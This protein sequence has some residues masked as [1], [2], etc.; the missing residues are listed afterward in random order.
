[1]TKVIPAEPRAEES[2]VDDQRLRTESQS[3]SPDVEKTRRLKTP[4]DGEEFDPY[5]YGPIPISTSFFKE[6]IS[7]QLPEA[8]P[9]ELYDGA[10]FRG[11]A[12]SPDRRQVLVRQGVFRELGAR[13]AHLLRARKWLM[14]SMLMVIVGSLLIWWFYDHRSS[15]DTAR[16]GSTHVE[17]SP[18]RQNAE[19]A[20]NVLPEEERPKPGPALDDEAGTIPLQPTAK[21]N[22][23]ISASRPTGA[24][25]SR[26]VNSKPGASPSTTKT[27]SSSSESLYYDF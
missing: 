19:L 3:T 25:K 5:R 22:R 6:L 23:D 9:D 16:K 15:L 8:L 26:T 4:S 14:G 20:K 21:D 1:M 11:A 24:P 12:P 17:P 13:D 18:M 27:K 2:P 7:T 10:L